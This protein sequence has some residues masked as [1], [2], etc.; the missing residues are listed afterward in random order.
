VI[1][2]ELSAR[3]IVGS[4][5]NPRRPLL[6]SHLFVRFC[7]LHPGNFLEIKPRTR[8]EGEFGHLSEK[9]GGSSGGKEASWMIGG[10]NSQNTLF[11]KMASID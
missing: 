1:A 4:L 9:K 8:K 2:S 5:L 11:K 6:F 7:A 10:Q 3:N